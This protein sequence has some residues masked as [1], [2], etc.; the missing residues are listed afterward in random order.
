MD[1]LINAAAISAV[2]LARCGSVGVGSVSCQSAPCFNGLWRYIACLADAAVWMMAVCTSALDLRRRVLMARIAK[3]KTRALAMGLRMGR[4][5]C[6]FGI[7][8]TMLPLLRLL[9]L[10]VDV[11]VLSKLTSEV[12]NLK[13]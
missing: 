9:L 6:G 12:E 8:A 11:V 5:R 10:R 3:V 7:R 1:E 2:E 13:A 4:Q